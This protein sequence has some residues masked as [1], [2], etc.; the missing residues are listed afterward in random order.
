MPSV[1]SKN[2]LYVFSTSNTNFRRAKHQVFSIFCGGSFFYLYY[3]QRGKKKTCFLF[4]D[5]GCSFLLTTH[6]VFW[7]YAHLLTQ[8]KILLIVTQCVSRALCNQKFGHTNRF[9]FCGFNGNLSCQSAA[10]ASRLP[11]ILQSLHLRDDFPFMQLSLQSML[12][13]TSHCDLTR[14]LFQMGSWYIQAD[15]HC[16]HLS[17]SL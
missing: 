7:F 14:M 15:L 10:A 9:F 13:H 16:G 3:N 6:T 4:T 12:V 2:K 11:N 8:L 1:S 17:I 5:V